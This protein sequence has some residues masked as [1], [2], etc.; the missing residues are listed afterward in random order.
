MLYGRRPGD[1]LREAAP[2]GAGKTHI[3]LAHERDYRP[4]PAT[5]SQS[6][7]PPDNYADD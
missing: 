6:G 4:P 5:S 1:A 3:V 7:P 2:G